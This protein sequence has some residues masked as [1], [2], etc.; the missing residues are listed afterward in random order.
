[1]EVVEQEEA[2]QDAYNA[3]SASTVFASLLVC[4]FTYGDNTLRT[5]TVKL[6]KMPPAVKRAPSPEKSSSAKQPDNPAAAQR[7]TDPADTAQ[8]GSK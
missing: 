4:D 3:L 8:Q 7:G 2:G 6:L 5:S 1:M